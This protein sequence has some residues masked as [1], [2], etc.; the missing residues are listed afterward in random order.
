MDSS[1]LPHPAQHPTVPRLPDPYVS[2]HTSATSS[3]HRRR[4]PPFKTHMNRDAFSGR[5]QRQS[6]RSAS[7]PLKG[8][9][10]GGDASGAHVP[11]SSTQQTLGTEVWVSLKLP[12]SVFSLSQR[13]NGTCPAH[14]P[15]SI[16]TGR[17]R[18]HHCRSR[19]ASGDLDFGR[20]RLRFGGPSGW[21]GGALVPALLMSRVKDLERSSPGKQIH[22]SF[23]FK[24]LSHPFPSEGAG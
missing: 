21:R 8:P 23:P 7:Q 13:R 22:F 5:R 17:A 24:A 1:A 19:T 3:R 4:T 14:A 18:R 11:R 9:F 6:P 12:T 2:L 20:H 16:A 15:T 10:V